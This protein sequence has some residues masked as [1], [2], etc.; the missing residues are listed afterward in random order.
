MKTPTMADRV[1]EYLAYRRALDYQLRFEGRLLRS[2][3]RSAKR[4]LGWLEMAA[5]VIL[6]RSGFVSLS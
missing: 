4:Y 6:L 1:E 2:F 3:D 5:C